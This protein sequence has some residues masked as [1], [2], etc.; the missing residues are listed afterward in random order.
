MIRLARKSDAQSIADIYNHYVKNT[1]VTFDEKPAD[2]R[3]LEKKIGALAEAD[4]WFVWEQDGRVAG[5]AYAA[6]WKSRCAYRHTLEAS[7]YIRPGMTGCGIGTQLYEKLLETLAVQGVHV[8]IA[9]IAI[10]NDASVAL[11]E[12]LGFFKVAHFKE[13]G[14]K[15]GRWIDVGYW[16]RILEQ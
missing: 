7:V 4:R 16:Q 14:S 9:G 8:V 6:E 5:Y 13:T 12:K 10:P 1:V 2:V 11:H 3:D 15:Q